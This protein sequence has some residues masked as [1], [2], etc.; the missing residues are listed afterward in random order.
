MSRGTR[1]WPVDADQGHGQPG[2]QGI[3]WGRGIVRGKGLKD[4][5]RVFGLGSWEDVLA[6]D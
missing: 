5:P 3:G 4:D 6:I 1:G 2:P